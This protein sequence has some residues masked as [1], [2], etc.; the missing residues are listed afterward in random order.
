MQEGRPL[1]GVFIGLIV[2]FANVAKKWAFSEP[3]VR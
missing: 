3:G 2:Q 1:R